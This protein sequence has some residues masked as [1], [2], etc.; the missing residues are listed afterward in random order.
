M[1]VLWMRAGRSLLHLTSGAVLV[2]SIADP[3]NVSKT[4]ILAQPF[5]LPRPSILCV[6]HRVVSAILIERYIWFLDGRAKRINN[7]PT[8][9]Q[10][11]NETSSS[12]LQGLD[13]ALFAGAVKMFDA[14]LEKAG[15]ANKCHCRI[16]QLFFQKNSC[17]DL[18]LFIRALIIQF[19]GH[20]MPMPLAALPCIHRCHHCHRSILQMLPI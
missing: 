17:E 2:K 4:I 8:K 1:Y 16:K 18:L 6:C 5:D 19:R 9:R 7:R 13:T 12:D 20:A 10:D 11:M 3:G 15:C 14:R